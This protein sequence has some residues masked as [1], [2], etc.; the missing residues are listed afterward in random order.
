M[1][2]ITISIVTCNYKTRRKDEEKD[3]HFSLKTPIEITKV[4]VET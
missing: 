2:T 4:G 3:Q 1:A